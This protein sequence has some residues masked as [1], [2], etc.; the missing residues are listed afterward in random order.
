VL[1]VSDTTWVY[2]GLEGEQKE[3][4][5]M[6][7]KERSSPCASGKVR[8][9]W[10][11]PLQAAEYLQVSRKSVYELVREGSLPFYRWRHALRFKRDELDE[12]IMQGRGAPAKYAKREKDGV[13][14]EG[15]MEDEGTQDLTE[16]TEAPGEAPDDVGE[17]GQ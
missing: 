9:S 1:N 3:K 2:T 13:P 4:K 11:T 15:P 8:S 17:A 5:A 12:M 6:T 14:A 10:M 7:S 16:G